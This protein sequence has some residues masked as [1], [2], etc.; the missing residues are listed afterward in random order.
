MPKYIF[1]TN[2]DAMN[3]IDGLYIITA[4]DIND[5]SKILTT[6]KYVIDT[7][8]SP[9]NYDELQLTSLWPYSLETSNIKNENSFYSSFKEHYGSTE[10]IEKSVLLNEIISN[11]HGG[12]IYFNGSNE[13]LSKV[14]KQIYGYVDLT[15]LDNLVNYTR[16]QN[17]DHI[18]MYDSDYQSEIEFIK[19]LN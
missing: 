5:L 7:L 18:N 9:S 17:I 2:V 4:K 13:N 15:N 16:K 1:S 19:N 12:G 6:N 3:K 14:A 8:F 11:Q 10:A